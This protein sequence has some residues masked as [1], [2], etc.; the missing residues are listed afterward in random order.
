MTILGPIQEG[1]LGWT[2][3][4]EH[5]LMDGRVLHEKWREKLRVPPP[6]DPDMPMSIENV[7]FI[8]HNGMATY[9]A[10]DLRDEHLMTQE[11]AD[12]KAAGGESMVE[13]S[14]IGI[15]CDIQGVRRIAE[16]N[17]IHVV[18]CTGFY[19]EESLPRRYLGLSAAEYAAVMIDEVDHGM[20]GTDM[21]PGVLKIAI[22]NF[23]RTEENT[24]RATGRAAAETGLSITLHCCWKPGADPV[25]AIKILKEEGADPTRVVIAHVGGSFVESDL[26]ALVTRPDESWRLKL[27]SVRRILDLGANICTEFLG[28]NLADDLTG[29]VGTTDWH[30]L[31]GLYALIREGYA[32]QIVLGTDTCCKMLTRRFGGEGYLRLWNFVIPT[33]RNILDIPNRVIEKIFVENPARI[34]AY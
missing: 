18:G 10:V 34:L 11:A 24:L 4:H 14:A 9:D 1:E 16:A 30:R 33:M 7:G 3:M 32:G 2:S 31:A 20:E 15:R 22:N 6:V 5:I 12:F 8:S 13:C 19:A 21:Y 29:Y 23:T 26:R 27:D 17:G 28:Q 25:A